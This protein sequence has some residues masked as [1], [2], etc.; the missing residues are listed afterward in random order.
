MGRGGCGQGL[1]LVP[2][3]GVNPQ[4][5]YSL[6]PAANHSQAPLGQL[7]Q[8]MPNGLLVARADLL[9]P[10]QTYRL[11][12]GTGGTGR[13][14]GWEVSG[15]LGSTSGVGGRQGLG[16]TGVLGWGALMSWW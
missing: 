7:F 1:R 12:V 16:G 8:V 14:W 11:Q 9:R 5:R 2:P 3:Q 10:A 15:G 6:H 13:H 4:V